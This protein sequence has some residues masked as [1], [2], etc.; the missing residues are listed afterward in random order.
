MPRN[1]RGDGN[2]LSG[3]SFY[4]H[5]CRVL[6]VPS[7]F[8][9]ARSCTL[10]GVQW[11]RWDEIQGG[12]KPG[13]RPGKEIDSDKSIQAAFSLLVDMPGALLHDLSW[14]QERALKLSIGTASHTVFVATICL[15]TRSKINVPFVKIHPLMFYFFLSGFLV[16]KFFC[17]CFVFSI[18]NVAS[19]VV[20][21]LFLLLSLSGI[22]NVFPTPDT[23]GDYKPCRFNFRW[24]KYEKLTTGCGSGWWKGK[25]KIYVLYS[26]TRRRT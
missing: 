18:L 15:C 16:N 25:L 10:H 11:S 3:T 12:H 24:G 20:L 1:H 4:L 5:G 22:W 2:I 7:R 9:L 13:R 21:C 17:A 19:Y 6:S 14:Q 8:P 23:S 26:G